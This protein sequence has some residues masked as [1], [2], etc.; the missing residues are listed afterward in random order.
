MLNTMKTSPLWHSWSFPG[1]CAAPWF[2]CTAL[3]TPPGSDWGR[4]IDWADELCTATGKKVKHRERDIFS[5]QF[6]QLRLLLQTWQR[7]IHIVWFKAISIYGM[8]FQCIQSLIS[9]KEISGYVKHPLAAMFDDYWVLSMLSVNMMW[10][11]LKYIV[12]IWRICTQ[13]NK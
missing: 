5:T 13:E 12:L 9:N 4:L 8:H 1:K 3:G 7:E 6:T 2:L 11:F 10:P